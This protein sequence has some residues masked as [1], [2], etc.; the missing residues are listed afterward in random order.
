MVFKLTS[1]SLGCL[2]AFLP[3]LKS[4]I[5]GRLDHFFLGELPGRTP[6]A[7][8]DAEVAGALKVYM[9]EGKEMKSVDL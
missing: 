2:K 4:M 9:V 3:S 6:L 7:V 5:D 8:A 1:H